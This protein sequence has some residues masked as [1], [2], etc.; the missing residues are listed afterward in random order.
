MTDIVIALPENPSKMTPQ[1]V[2]D[3]L[4]ADTPFSKA[5]R[6]FSDA[7]GELEQAA[8]QRW[9]PGPFEARQMQIAAMIR[10]VKALGMAGEA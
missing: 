2:F 10:I 8:M 1:Q 6:V 7:C 5:L 3:V 4:R 9:P